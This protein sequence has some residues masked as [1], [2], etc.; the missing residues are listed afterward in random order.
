MDKMGRTGHIPRDPR[1]RDT[2]DAEM[3][4][5]SREGE[6]ASSGRDVLGPRGEAG[7]L[8]WETVEVWRRGRRGCG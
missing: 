6:E 5:M 8:G 2:A 4:G 7:R 3:P 1:F